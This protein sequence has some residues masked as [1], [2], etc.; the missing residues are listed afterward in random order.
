MK[1]KFFLVV[2]LLASST[3]YA[4]IYSEPSSAGNNGNKAVYLGDNAGAS[5]TSNTN[6]NT[7]IGYNAGENTN[8]DSTV[9]QGYANTFIGAHSGQNNTIGRSN[10]FVG[11][12]SGFTTTGGT[13]NVY[14]GAESGRLNQTGGGNVFIGAN[15][16]ESNTAS[17]NV[18]IGEEAGYTN[19]GESNIFLGHEA[20]RNHS[21]SNM[22]IVDNSSTANPLIYGEFDNN[23]LIFNTQRI[24]IGYEN[25]G[26]S[27]F[28][29]GGFPT[30]TSPDLTNYRLFIKGGILAEEVRVRTDLWPDYVFTSEYNLMPLTEVEQFIAENGHLPNM[31]SAKEVEEEGLALGDMV[32]RQQEKI[33]ELTLH[34]IEQQKEMNILR[35][36]VQLLL[37]SAQNEKRDK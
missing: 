17:N 31:P 19:L 24:G 13:F 23:I 22:L 21:G 6:N 30:V 16:G 25:L 34:L 3:F 36:Q 26:S 27:E 11:D 9:N 32:K 35:E 37:N 29:F 15:S 7:F 8:G 4:Q 12:R 18:F 33:E 28:G 5:A 1:L 20:G 10:V 2:G 14:I